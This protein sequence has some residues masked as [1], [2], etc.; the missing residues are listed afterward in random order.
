MAA[1]QGD[2]PAGFV[3]CTAERSTL[4]A[5]TRVGFGKVPTVAARQGDAPAGFLPCT[6]D[7]F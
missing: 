6:D 2:A 5:A 3:P 4:A 7:R 1:R